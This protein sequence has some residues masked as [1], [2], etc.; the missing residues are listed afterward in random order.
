MR[1]QIRGFA[2]CVGV[3]GDISEARFKEVKAAKETCLKALEIEEK[4]V[5]V[6]VF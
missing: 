2:K 3:S 1:Y 4:L 5:L 6:T